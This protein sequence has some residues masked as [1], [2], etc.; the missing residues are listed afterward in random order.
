M[1]HNSSLESSVTCAV[2]G[3]DCV[4]PD[5]AFAEHVVTVMEG[6][7]GPLKVSSLE[8]GAKLVVTDGVLYEGQVLEALGCAAT[9]LWALI[10]PALLFVLT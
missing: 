10:L 9:H 7:S 6:T 2:L 8:G 4:E 3:G 1:T 5:K